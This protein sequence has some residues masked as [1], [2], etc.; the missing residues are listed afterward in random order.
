MF[1]LPF[2]PKTYGTARLHKNTIVNAYHK[3][4]YLQCC[5]S[6]YIC[7]ASMARQPHFQSHRAC[8]SRDV[9]P[10]KK[11]YTQLRWV[12]REVFMQRTFGEENRNSEPLECSSE[13]QCILLSFEISYR[14]VHT[15]FLKV[16][17]IEM[18]N[19]QQHRSKVMRSMLI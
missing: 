12:A 3:S 19:L 17:G 6:T 8:Y 10:A 7:E 2:S 18:F 4:Y 13:F 5:A 9:T 16:G 15:E 1:L 11:I 14:L